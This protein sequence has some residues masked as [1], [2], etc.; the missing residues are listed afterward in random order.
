MENDILRNVEGDTKLI[1]GD[2][3]GQ[4]RLSATATF[5]AVKMSPVTVPANG[6]VTRVN[7]NIEPGEVAGRRGDSERSCCFLEPALDAV[8]FLLA[9]H[10]VSRLLFRGI[11]I[12][13]PSR[14]VCLGT[15]IFSLGLVQLGLIGAWVDLTKYVA[16]LHGLAKPARDGDDRPADSRLQIDLA[17]GLEVTGQDR[18]ITDFPL[19]RMGDL[20]FRQPFRACPRGRAFPW[21]V[22]L[23]LAGLLL[24][25]AL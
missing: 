8:D 16:R 4:G 14:L 21:F 24:N 23:G 12:D 9:D 3:T 5:P 6:A 2:D 7:S 1:D 18:V 25:R 17:A 13:C 11:Q 15:V 20:D 10:V 22:R 19:D